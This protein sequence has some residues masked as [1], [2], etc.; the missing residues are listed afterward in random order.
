MTNTFMST[1]P[2]PRKI[3]YVLVVQSRCC[4]DADEPEIRTIAVFDMKSRLTTSCYFS[5]HKQVQAKEF[6]SR[7]IDEVKN[8]GTAIMTEKNVSFEARMLHTLGYDN[9]LG[10]K[11]VIRMTYSD[12][13][14]SNEAEILDI[15]RKYVKF[16]PSV[17]YKSQKKAAFIGIGVLKF[18]FEVQ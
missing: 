8:D 11:E 14:V 13:R 2:L 6:L 18:Y 17:P 12:L 9:P 16:C 1:N 10:L 7:L 15:I 3:R 4:I 5:S